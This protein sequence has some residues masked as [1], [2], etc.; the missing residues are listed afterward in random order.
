[1]ADI[2]DVFAPG[3]K[4]PVGG[5]VDVFAPDYQPPKPVGI[6]GAFKQ[7]FMATIGE[8]AK[9]AGS[10]SGIQGV[11]NYG[12]RTKEANAPIGDESIP[13]SVARGVG[14]LTGWLPAIAG[15][16]AIIP[17][18]PEGAIA[19]GL[20]R[21][22]A[23]MALPAIS[24][25]VNT[26]SDLEAKGVDA[27]TAGNAGLAS[28]ATT[29]AMG[30]VPVGLAGG[31]LKRAV[32]GAASGLATGEAG[33]LA[34]N[35]TLSEHPDLQQAFTGKQAVVESVIG[36]VLGGVMG[37]R[38]PLKA[39]INTMT[40]QAKADL[41]N[42]DNLT[43][44]ET[45]SRA[46]GAPPPEAPPVIPTSEVTPITPD[47]T[48]ENIA[49][50][51]AG[52][53]TMLAEDRV[54][55]QQYADK[56]RELDAL[57]P[58]AGEVPITD[59][60][61]TGRASNFALEP[62]GEIASRATGLTPE[63]PAVNPD[64][65]NLSYPVDLTGQD[66][67]HLN[68]PPKTAMSIALETA[69]RRATL[70]S[71]FAD[72]EGGQATLRA[73][74]S[75]KAWNLHEAENAAS[76]AE[77][78]KELPT[79]LPNPSALEGIARTVKDPGAKV[80]VQDLGRMLQGTKTADE[81][82]VKLRA[83]ADAWDKVGKRTT[84]AGTLRKVAEYIK[85]EKPSEQ[86]KTEEAPQAK[87]SEAEQPAQVVEAPA[88]VETETLNPFQR[89]AAS[90]QNTEA[91]LAERE[92]GLPVREAAKEA[93]LGENIQQ[94]AIE[95]T[96]EISSAEPRIAELQ[97]KGENRTPTEA[98]ELGEL[99]AGK[100]EFQAW[101]ALEKTGEHEGGIGG[102]NFAERRDGQGDHDTVGV[103]TVTKDAKMVGEALVAIRD[104]MSPKWQ[105]LIDKLLAVPEAVKGT[106][107]LSGATK[108]NITNGAARLGEHINGDIT[109]HNGAG[110][111]TLLHE[112]VHARTAWAIDNNKA[113]RAEVQ[114]AF[115]AAKASG[116]FSTDAYMFKNLHEFLAVST[117]EPQMQKLLESIPSLKGKNLLGRVWDAV[118]KMLG[119]QPGQRS[120]LQDVMGLVH[121]ADAPEY[122]GTGGVQYSERKLDFS[123]GPTAAV[124]AT[125]TVVTKA[126]DII[127]KLKPSFD[128]QYLKW[129][130]LTHI[131]DMSEGLF[132][133]VKMDEAG[134]KI[135]RWGDALNA[136]IN[137]I[138]D[139]VNS[140]MQSAAMAKEFNHTT[141]KIYD[142]MQ[143]LSDPQRQSLYKLMGEF[144]LARVFPNLKFE[145]HTWLT[146]ADKP[147]YRAAKQLYDQAGVAKVYDAAAAHN[148]TL[149]DAGMASML[150]SMGQIYGVPE[151][152][153]RAIDPRNGMNKDVDALTHWAVTEGRMDI[154][155]QFEQALSLHEAKKQ[156]SYFSIGRDG[157][158]MANFHVKDTPE[159][160]AAVQAAM[161]AAGVSDQI[162]VKPGD[163]HVF[164]MFE[165]QNQ[166][167][168]VTKQLDALN[169]A[170]HLEKPYTAGKT[171]DKLR[172]LDSSAPSFIR[173]MLAKIDEDANMAGSDPVM[174]AQ[175][176]AQKEL[177]RRMY[178]GMLPESSVSKFYA[179]RSGTPGYSS[180][181]ARSFVKR[182]AAGAYF[183]SSHA[184]RAEQTIAMARIRESVKDFGNSGSEFFDLGKQQKSVAVL[185]ELNQ[186]TA[187]N[188]NPLHTPGYDL[189]GAMGHTFYLSAS[190]SF[191]IQNLAQ[192][193]QITLPYLGGRHG[194]VAS[195]RALAAAAKDIVPLLKDSIQQGYKDGKWTGILDAT[196]A[197]DR[198]AHLSLSD[199]NA[200][201]ALISSG[202]ADWTQGGELSNIQ[203]GQSPKLQNAL[204][205]ANLA[206]YY[207]ES[208]NR[209]QT[210]L[211]TFRLEMKKNGG[212]EAKAIERMV[213]AVDDTQINYASEN[214][215]R[216]ISKHGVLGSITPLV[217][218]FQQFNL[219]V[220]QTLS[221]LV[222][223]AHGAEKGSPERMEAVRSLAGMMAATG[224]MAGT[225]GIPFVGAITGAY[226]ALAGDENHPV[227][228][229]S[230][231]QNFLSDI[232]GSDG[233]RVI[234]HGALNYMTGA[235]VA[236]KLG[237]ENLLPYTQLFS[238]LA[239]SR[240]KMQ[241]RLNSGA[242]SF[243]G[244]MV[245]MPVNV[246]KGLSDMS[247]GDL[248]KGAIQMAP[249]AVRGS[250]KAA[251]QAEKGFTDSKGVK[252]GEQTTW[253]GAVQ[254][255][256]FN[257]T[258][259]STQ[260]EAQQGIR[261]I[262]GALQMR[263]HSLEDQFIKAHEAKDVEGRQ[264][265][266]ADIV[267]F[268]KAH[269]EVQINIGAAMRSRA[270]SEA[271]MG[272]TGGVAGR[273]KQV[274]FIQ[275]QTRFAQ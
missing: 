180:D 221:K 219:G 103:Q 174:V 189:V 220:M 126:M 54:T 261:A 182:V 263:V 169:A 128:R 35:A 101:D 160:H 140:M 58:S 205:T 139:K 98:R 47:K 148:K 203:T 270:K 8:A 86:A 37:H 248:M 138:R 77:S 104:G 175:R 198:A 247:D 83:Q 52:W 211:S 177:L 166:M 208:L 229:A 186:R 44:P 213:A 137:P 111:M 259:K 201:K 71:A 232:V 115:D 179:R 170:G 214:R 271:I 251:D 146:N 28:A 165:T 130:Q 76:V 269:P 41:A 274:P 33:R 184:T 42:T 2:V 24:S 144:Q 209:M 202:R 107:L 243:M 227:D 74:E 143:G 81:L 240:M 17:A 136:A 129:S 250:L 55:K 14:G 215:A 196:I 34:Q 223:Q 45:P 168:M 167:L 150:K 171:V 31:L 267:E 151:H 230:D 38:S 141:K 161:K 3:Y 207:G 60:L 162:V 88:R 79:A 163:T 22:A 91:K 116:K 12:E 249:S 25:K 275:Q 149:H 119:L 218:A 212:D 20:A 118:Q 113:F 124:N 181:M 121:S 158:F 89:A 65:A 237:Q 61:A 82:V 16:A 188:M 268:R 273:A 172:E 100:D 191:I 120:L 27:N 233:A 152:L 30:A 133:L 164:S 39:E 109:L 239:D 154:K 190:P 155:D 123:H 262:T 64:Q 21:G 97:A 32:T 10:L 222:M 57:R 185:D 62:S 265:A 114:A 95:R 246:I 56:M 125:Q 241:D 192:P 40:E 228:A 46:T 253:E 72:R 19:L 117:T 272:I 112:A 50:V 226:N 260:G 90:V 63:K 6:G 66:L 29:L 51:K 231:Y 99:L 252:W 225:M 195:G 204:K 153:W 108:T 7:G 134:N 110:T 187:N 122:K 145:D 15:T 135:P 264:Q 43:K 258:T 80:P 87:P 234:A 1:M 236:S 53:D 94:H 244:P 102:E 68:L 69:Q 9:T 176:D 256:G 84:D 193:Y 173:G 257:P 49:A 210:A 131:A 242:L 78:G 75:R 200:L 18:A 4:P 48:A 92:A 36:S 266:L 183:V 67:S 142:Q 194:F 156:E 105:K 73:I 23:S 85:P 235:D 245:G 216:A 238:R 26:T 5:I 199:K 93:P 224:V 254:A 59:L 132:G 127:S 96:T 11:E 197:V 178:I 13:V 206:S 255:L 147:K 159:A 70:D 217:F 157:D 106:F